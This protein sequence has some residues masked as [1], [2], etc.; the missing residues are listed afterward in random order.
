MMVDNAKKIIDYIKSHEKEII[1]NELTAPEIAE[2]FGVTKQLIYHHANKVNEEL[3]KRKETKTNEGL[4]RIAQDIEEGIPLELIFSQPYA[5]P[6]LTKR[7]SEN[8]HRAKD[9]I[10]N[11]LELR[12]IV[13]PEKEIN[14]Y[15]LVNAKLKIYVNIL[16]IEEVL[17]T[18]PKI[19]KAELARNLDVSHRKVLGINNDIKKEPYRVLPKMPQRLYEIIKRNIH[20][21]MEYF[22][23]GS[24][25]AVYE[26]YSEIDKRTLRLI[27]D[28]YK[29]FVK[30]R[31]MGSDNK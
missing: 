30:K 11:R 2:K 28:G 22:N 29:P 17:K 24:K 26:K 14:R 12:E 15:A 8:I 5:R 19:N 3:F 1:N 27:I 31:P 6:F 16:Q 23:L 25:K 21:T 9:L 18:N 13:S 10:V 4:R 20:I 7:G